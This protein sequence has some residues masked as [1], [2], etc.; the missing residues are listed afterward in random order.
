MD[1]NNINE[2]WKK[3][4]PNL[5]AMEAANPFTVP[6]NYFEKLREQLSARIT[7]ESI[8]GSEIEGAFIIPDGYFEN[9]GEQIIS[10]A[11]LEDL[12]EENT[13]NGF[14]VPEHYFEDL[15]GNITSRI[16]VEEL[17]AV[18]SNNESFSVP[19]GYFDKLHQNILAKTTEAE[20][21]KVINIKQRSTNWIRYA[22]AA[23]IT[24]MIG[25]GIFLN[26]SPKEDSDINSALSKIPDT[27][28]VNYLQVNSSLGDSEAIMEQLA[29]TGIQPA[30]NNEFTE[31]EIESYLETTL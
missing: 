16:K 14:S 19:E 12:K 9:L 30:I 20:P 4:A 26:Y 23:C 5:A 11:H 17:A 6:N 8:A 22:A 25:T 10:R 27:E 3:D 21:A 28:I 7:I 29:E 18:T 31:D 15:A 1:L 24:A 13:G 2:D